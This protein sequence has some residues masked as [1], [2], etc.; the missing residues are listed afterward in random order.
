MAVSIAG[1]LS[2]LGSALVL[3][4]A[5]GLLYDVFRVLRVRLPKQGPKQPDNRTI[6]IE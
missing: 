6:V 5:I 4:L 3:G 2:A 1:Q